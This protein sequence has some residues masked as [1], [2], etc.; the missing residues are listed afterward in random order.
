M[1]GDRVKSL[2]AVAAITLLASSA[3]FA[4]DDTSAL[5]ARQQALFET[6]VAEP[7]NLAVMFDYAAVSM[8]LEDYEPAISALER[9]LIFNP[10]LPRVKLEL[11]VAYFRLGSYEVARFYF[12]EALAADPPPQVAERVAPFLSTIEARTAID[13]FSGFVAFGPV[14]SSNATLGPNDR[15]ILF[16]PEGGSPQGVSLADDQTPE[17]DYG[18]RLAASATWSRDLRRATEDRWISTLSYAGLR[19]ASEEAGEFDA[20]SIDTGPRLSLSPRAF[21]PTLRPYL[22]GGVVR[23]AG[24]LLYRQTGGGAQVSDS[25]TPR[26]GVFGALLAQYRDYASEDDEFD[27]VYAFASAGASLQVDRAT[28]LRG[29]VLGERDDAREADLSNTEFGLRFTIQRELARPAFASGWGGADPWRLSLFG[30][31]SRRLFD[32]PRDDVD[33]DVSRRDTDAR[34]SLR[35]VAPVGDDWA[36]AAEASWFERFSNLPNNELR[37]FEVGF[38][39][40]RTF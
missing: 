7:E 8:R 11:G 14:Y 26:L 16:T 31:L 6:M 22:E 9:M 3:A 20:L 25:L 35:L 4:Q 34:A 32:E 13:A 12:E 18:V 5:R 39:A 10:D 2:L 37:N 24:D 23:S 1:V 33:P 38:S 29:S 30:Q 28:V 19:Y 40:I 36:V 21:G 17:A 27:G 15:I